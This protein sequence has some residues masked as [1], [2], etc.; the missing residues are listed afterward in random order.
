MPLAGGTSKATRIGPVPT[1][2]RSV[3]AT[4]RLSGPMVEPGGEVALGSVSL[5]A[6]GAGGVAGIA[7]K[8]GAAG[9][10]GTAGAAGTGGTAGAAGSAGWLVCG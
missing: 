9:D 5:G 3:V 10:G 4:P 1:V 6:A 8:G 7:G 2:A